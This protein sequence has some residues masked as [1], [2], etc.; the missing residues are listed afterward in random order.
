VDDFIWHSL[1]TPVLVALATTL[2][3]E[4]AAKPRLEARKARILR[5]RAEVDEF[6]YAAQRLGLLAGALP[7]S[8]Q[9]QGIPDL[10]GYAREAISEL[11]AAAAD[12]TRVLSRLSL[13]YAIAHQAHIAKTAR[14]LGFLRGRC[15]VASED[16]VARVDDLKDVAGDL[17]YFDVYFRV[18]LGLGDS[19]EPLVKRLFWRVATQDEF[20]KETDAALTRHGLSVR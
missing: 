19:Q 3:V 1:A 2:A 10:M 5:S 11:D 16:P 7:D 4:Y 13:R 6:V 20:E 9:L 15:H 12:A 14:F 17:E 18:H 8:G